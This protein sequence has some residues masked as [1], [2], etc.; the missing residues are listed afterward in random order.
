MRT[1]SSLSSSLVVEDV[2]VGI[3]VIVGYFQHSSMEE[4]HS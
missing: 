2:M 1:L 4:G 3:V